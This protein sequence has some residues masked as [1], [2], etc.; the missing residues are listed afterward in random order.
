MKK[1]DKTP[2][3]KT[4]PS[5]ESEVIESL[6]KILSDRE[7]TSIEAMWMAEKG[8]ENA[9]MS[10]RLY[11]LKFNEIPAQ[12]FF[13]AEGVEVMELMK[14]LKKEMGAVILENYKFFGFG[15]QWIWYT[16]G[17]PDQPY[18]LH[19]K[20]MSRMEANK[21]EKPYFMEEDYDDDEEEVERFSNSI[22]SE[23]PED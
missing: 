15:F 22:Y 8:D 10:A 5:T 6:D 21:Y 16:L 19:T 1:S 23:E 13:T 11:V 14:L 4:I 7:F 2:D 12:K 18:L 3:N 17:F 20:H 9:G